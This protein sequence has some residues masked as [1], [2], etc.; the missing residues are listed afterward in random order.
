[1]ANGMAGATLYAGRRADDGTI[2]PAP[3]THRASEIVQQIAGGPDGQSKMLGAF[4]KHLTVP[5]EG[6]IVVRPNADVLSS[7]VPEDGHDWRVL[8]IKEAARSPASSP[9]RSTEKRSGSR[10]ATK[11]PGTIASNVGHIL[12]DVFSAAN[13]SGGGLLYNLITITGAFREFVASAEGQEAIGNIFGTIATIAAQ[14]GPIFGALITQ[15]GAIAPS[16]AP[17]FQAFS[18]GH[19]QPDQLARVPALAAIAPSLTTLGTALAEGLAA[20]GP[21]ALGPL[22]A[23]LGQ[24]VTALAPLP[25]LIGSTGGRDGGGGHRGEGVGSCS[26]RG[27]LFG[28]RAGWGVVLRVRRYS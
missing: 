12:S 23:S 3:N 14:L 22:C 28:N 27:V 5:G 17:L 9:E 26:V 18:P 11:R 15:I 25:P 24:V 6:W 10:P 7:E 8:S 1:M 2:E 19:G 4:G 20:L 21:A 16:L 13:A